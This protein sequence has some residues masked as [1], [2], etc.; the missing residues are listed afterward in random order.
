[1]QT[2]GL[3]GDCQEDK[4]ATVVSMTRQMRELERKFAIMMRI[5][6][7]CTGN[8]SADQE[9]ENIEC[10]YLFRYAQSKMG[11]ESRSSCTDVIDS[12][13]F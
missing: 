9:C 10:T 7:N 8:R 3:C 13:Q 5:C 2:I 4:Q 11:F 12:L 6:T 1:M